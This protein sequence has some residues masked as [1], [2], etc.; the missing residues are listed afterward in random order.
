M[1]NPKNF[2]FSGFAKL[3]R[4]GNLLIIA[5][6]QYMT[7]IFI[8][9]DQNRQYDALTDPK[10]FLLSLSSVLIAAAGYIINDYYDVKIDYINKPNRVVVGKVLKRRVVMVAHTMINF[11]GIGLGFLVSPIVAIINFLCALLL[12]LYSNQLKRM[13]LAGNL[14]VALLTGLSIYIVE[15]VFRSGNQFVLVYAAF[16]FGY[17]VIREIVKDMEDVKGD[18]TFGCKTI[19][20]VYGLRVTKWII[21]AFS[22]IFTMSLSAALISINSDFITILIV[23]N[24]AML[25]ML[26]VLLYNADTVKQLHNLSTATKIMMMIGVLSMILI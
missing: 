26:M 14:S 2:S 11:V 6:A 9:A 5:L 13:P 22:L 4:I 1:E 21:L 25:T 17:T 8:I 19:P 7:A 10:L 15:I 3:T 20:I 24:V 18:E 12:W 16:A 23:G